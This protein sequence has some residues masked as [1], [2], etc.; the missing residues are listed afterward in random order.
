[1]KRI[2]PELLPKIVPKQPQ[3]SKTTE[4]SFAQ[5]LKTE[6]EKIGT[7]NVSKHAA[8]RMTE[9]NLYL[10]ESQWRKIDSK[11]SV[12]RG[13]GIVDSLVLAGEAAL[14]VNTKNNTVVTAMNRKEAASHIFTNINGA[15]VL[16]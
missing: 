13:K 14:I 16:E 3:P 7:L 12:A 2:Q 1:M 10:S 9:R 15:I 6:T 4:P 11:V 8:Q 5:R